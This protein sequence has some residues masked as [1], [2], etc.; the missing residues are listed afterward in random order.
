MTN[1]MTASFLF[2]KIACVL[3]QLHYDDNQNNDN[4]NTNDKTHRQLLL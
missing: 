2:F 1:P 4:E 3:G